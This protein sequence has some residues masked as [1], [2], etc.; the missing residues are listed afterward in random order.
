MTEISKNPEDVIG[1][2][3][4]Q[5]PDQGIVT[6]GEGD[7][8]L[9]IIDIIKGDK[10][11]I[12]IDGQ[13]IQ[14][15]F[16]KE[17]LK[18]IDPEI[19]REA[20]AEAIPEGISGFRPLPYKPKPS[21]IGPERDGEGIS[22]FRPLPY[23]PRPSI[24]EPE[25]DGEGISGFRPLPSETV[26][27]IIEPEREA[28]IDAI[29]AQIYEALEHDDGADSVQPLDIIGPDGEEIVLTPAEGI[30]EEPE[31]I[32]VEIDGQIITLLGPDTE[33][34]EAERTQ[35]DN[36]P[37]INTEEW[38]SLLEQLFGKQ[39][40]NPNELDVVEQVVEVEAA[41]LDPTALEPDAVD[42]T[43]IHQLP[44]MV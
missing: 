26:P 36:Q 5:D 39:V 12:E 1:K 28:D 44:S 40:D 2:D 7:N 13:D 11:A 3:H 10:L 33:I 31:G 14:L 17:E 21:I 38:T 15:P 32:T 9:S 37:A 27:S 6:H 8:D 43:H 35:P 22:G 34:F 30:V 20:I 24:I 29:I 18:D 4:V 41:D 16:S 19:L 42:E 25:G 23:K